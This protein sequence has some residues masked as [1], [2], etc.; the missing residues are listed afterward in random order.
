GGS[1]SSGQSLPS[2]GNPLLASDPGVLDM[3][4]VDV[5]WRS[6]VFQRSE[7]LPWASKSSHRDP[8]PSSMRLKNAHP[9]LRP[10]DGRILHPPRPLPHH[11]RPP[12]HPPPP[13]TH[14][15]PGASHSKPRDVIRPPPR[16]G[17]LRFLAHLMQFPRVDVPG[18][19]PGPGMA[20]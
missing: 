15:G 6:W 11:W 4:G 18:R 3:G 8:F 20:K 19:G 1:T 16:P 17:H 5:L 10:S 9:R 12:Y 14:S 7:Y 13:P 2:I